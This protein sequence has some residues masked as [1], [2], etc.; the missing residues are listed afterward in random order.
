M[1]LSIVLIIISLW[2]NTLIAQH[3][4]I[5]VTN[6]CVTFRQWNTPTHSLAVFLVDDNNDISIN[7]EFKK[8]GKDLVFIPEFPLLATVSYKLKS[9]NETF[10]F[11]LK[12]KI[13]PIPIVTK[14]H[15]TSDTLPENLLRMYIQFSNPMKVVGN[16]EKI[17]L[18]DENEQEVKGA[19]FNNVY[20]LWDDSQT[21]LTIIFDPSRVKTGLL[22]NEALGRALQLNK[23]YKIVIQDLEDIYGQ[24][25]TESYVKPFSV[26][27]EDVISPDTD[28]WEFV[29]PKSLSKKPLTIQFKNSI[30]K[31]SLLHR[32]RLFNTNNAI[33]KG[34]ILIE[35]EEKTWKFIP[36]EKWIAGNYTLKINS[37]LADPSGNNLNGLFDHTIGSLKNKQEGEIIEIPIKI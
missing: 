27:A 28:S 15:P 17:Q 18:I 24:K 4:K 31:M 9:E 8:T 25:L 23:K 32:I 36:Q 35:N 34:T 1:K 30:D 29:L 10:N 33:I 11:S 16:I 13:H 12:E 37:R 19:I 6:E 7:G 26:I 22:A 21:Q 14:I 3:Q 20:E 2:L 5:T